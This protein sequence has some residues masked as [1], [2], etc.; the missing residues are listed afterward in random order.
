MR[1]QSLKA[2]FAALL[3]LTA[4]PVLGEEELPC[5]YCREQ[6]AHWQGELDRGVCDYGLSASEKQKC[7]TLHNDALANYKAKLKTCTPG[8]SGGSTTPAGGKRRDP[9]ATKKA[10]GDAA[11]AAAGVADVVGAGADEDIADAADDLDDVSYKP[12][13]DSGKRSPKA[14]GRKGP[15][16]LD[17]LEPDDDAGSAAATAGVFVPEKGTHPGFV[18]QP[19]VQP[20][21][22]RPGDVVDVT[23][24]LWAGCE[25]DC[26]AM[27]AL[28]AALW[29]HHAAAVAA[30]PPLDP[31][32]CHPH[33]SHIAPYVEKLERL[34]QSLQIARSMA[35]TRRDGCSAHLVQAHTYLTT[36]TFD[37]KSSFGL[38]FHEA[39]DLD[40]DGLPRGGEYRDPSLSFPFRAAL[41]GSWPEDLDVTVDLGACTKICDEINRFRA[42]P[43]GVSWISQ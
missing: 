9:E 24:L 17:D 42:C 37:V 31:K 19:L 27:G 7:L 40:P 33:Q 34:Y 5:D 11:D 18:P 13:S 10:I 14:G 29:H 16:S 20:K 21:P 25:A 39:A 23:Q 15:A 22:I 8:G 43:P 30:F 26:S 4:R 3:L 2:S 12:D 32:P 36:F 41:G 38:P 1:L 6:I 35:E 28:S